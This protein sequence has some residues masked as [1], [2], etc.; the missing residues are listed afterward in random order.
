MFM[1]R[2]KN[3][4]QNVASVAI[5]CS[6]TR[7]MRC[8]AFHRTNAMLTSSCAWVFS[9]DLIFT[10][11]FFGFPDTL[12]VHPLCPDEREHD[13]SGCRASGLTPELPV[14]VVLVTPLLVLPLL[15]L[16][17]LV[18]LPGV[19]RQP[20]RHFYLIDFM[21]FLV[22]ARCGGF[23][24]ALDFTRAGYRIVQST[25]LLS[26]FLQHRTNTDADLYPTDTSQLNKIVAA[27]TDNSGRYVHHPASIFNA[28]NW[29]NHS[30]RPDLRGCSIAM[31]RLGSKTSKNPA[32]QQGGATISFMF[33]SCTI[34]RSFAFF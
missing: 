26:F 13:P 27:T 23:E 31:W 25:L 32:A 34:S 28:L 22:P 3:F 33:R 14:H 1:V 10:A 16:Q 4:S 5:A 9:C 6:W 30:A 20:H 18:G 15:R 29:V 17:A 12:L 19:Q 11:T 2:S 24:K 8:P 21:K 7:S